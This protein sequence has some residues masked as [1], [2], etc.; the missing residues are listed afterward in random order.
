MKIEIDKVTAKP[1]GEKGYTFCYK[2]GEIGT[3]IDTALRKLTE[4]III[5]DKKYSTSIIVMIRARLDL[6]RK[7]VDKNRKALREN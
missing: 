1:L 7:E 2:G 3:N 6:V 5:K 4:R